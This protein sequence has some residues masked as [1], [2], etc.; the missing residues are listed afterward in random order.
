MPSLRPASF[1]LRAMIG[2]CACAAPLNAQNLITNGGFEEPAVP[3]DDPDGGTLLVAPASLPGGWELTAGSIDILRRDGAT[4]YQTP[5][6]AQAIDLNGISRGSIRLLLNAT[7]DAVYRLTFAI[8]GNPT[9]EPGIKRANFILENTIFATLTFNS[10][11]RSPTNMGWN[12][13]EYD[14]QGVSQP[15]YLQFQSTAGTNCGMMVDNVRLMKCLEITA[16]PLTQV[17]CAG[18]PA[19]FSVDAA[20]IGTQYRWRRNT[21]TLMNGPNITGATSPTLVIHSVSATDAGEYSCQVFNDCGELI[22]FA[23]TLS[24]APAPCPGDANGDQTVNFLD[25]SRVLELWN[26]NYAPG[27]GPG[28]SDCNGLV[29]FAEITLVLTNWSAVCR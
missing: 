13:Y 26:S 4:P 10:T 28:D 16:Q 29:D 8:A 9:C 14:F 7:G 27:T 1:S 25:V 12:T 20:G 21:T 6:G 3:A 24:V 23:A 2:V 22:S 11:G 18:T 19:L 15:R 5:E 17:R